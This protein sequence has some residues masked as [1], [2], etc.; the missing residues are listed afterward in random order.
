[1]EESYALFD[2]IEEEETVDETSLGAGVGFLLV[3]MHILN[4]TMGWRFN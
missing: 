1:M 3:G 2:W 4:I